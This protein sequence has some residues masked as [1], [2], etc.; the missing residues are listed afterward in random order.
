MLKN[1]IIARLGAT[2]GQDESVVTQ[3]MEAARRH[4]IRPFKYSGAE[5]QMPRG[6]AP[7]SR[8]LDISP[9]TFPPRPCIS[10]YSHLISLAD[11]HGHS[12]WLVILN[13]NGREEKA[14][15][16][17]HH[18]HGRRRQIYFRPE[19]QLLP[20]LERTV[21]ATLHPESRPS[22]HEHHI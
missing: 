22:S 3:G 5:F 11:D 10:V 4:R 2:D 1:V 20:S 18:W 8:A 16:H 21:L 9:C 19:N 17:H 14:D 12:I 7:S 6:A 13:F 15:S